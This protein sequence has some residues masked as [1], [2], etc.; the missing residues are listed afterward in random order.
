M[1]CFNMVVA[2]SDIWN[3]MSIGGTRPS[4]EYQCHTKQRK[5]NTCTGTFYMCNK[6]LKCHLAALPAPTHGKG[7]HVMSPI[8]HSNFSWS[9]D[10]GYGDIH[11]NSMYLCT[12]WNLEINSD[13]D[14][15]TIINSEFTKWLTL[16]YLSCGHMPSVLC[17]EKL[18]ASSSD[19]E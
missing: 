19:L 10:T 16:L 15:C 13:M 12:T 5:V 4:L 3:D 11:K 8:F 6:L 2:N 9:R 1:I 17:G 14:I 7:I 18:S